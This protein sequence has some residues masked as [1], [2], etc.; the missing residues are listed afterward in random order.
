[1]PAVALA[2]SAAQ[3]SATL[4]LKRG[5]SGSA[6]HRC[7][8]SPR[9]RCAVGPDRGPARQRCRSERA[10]AHA[11]GRHGR[12]AR[13]AA[14]QSAATLSRWSG[15]R[16][17][18]LATCT[19]QPPPPCAERNDAVPLGTAAAQSS[20]TLSLER[21][22][23]R[24]RASQLAALCPD[25]ELLSRRGALP[26]YRGTG[27]V[28]ATLSLGFARR[29]VPLGSSAAQSAAT[30]ALKVPTRVTARHLRAAVGR[31]PDQPRHAP[32]VLLGTAAAQSAGTLSVGYPI[33]GHVGLE[34][35]PVGG[36]DRHRA[37]RPADPTPSPTS[38][39]ATMRSRR[40]AS[41]TRR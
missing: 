32:F 21:R 8:P 38:V 33:E 9:R 6:G 5:D 37:L 41:S 17:V 23:Q 15:A 14:A 39:R 34:R 4:A 26:V 30:L 22:G 25:P 35:G 1:M 7:R 16:Q 13:P 24:G 36:D 18:P 19:A 10:T 28:A 12:P 2:T 20:A 27:A 11:Q 40:E 29:L 3:S 31:R